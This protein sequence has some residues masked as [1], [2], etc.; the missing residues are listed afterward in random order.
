MVPF[1]LTKNLSL[2]SAPDGFRFSPARSPQSLNRSHPCYAASESAQRCTRH[3]SSTPRSPPASA[4]SADRPFGLGGDSARRPVIEPGGR[5]TFKHESVPRAT[6]F[7]LVF[8]KRGAIHRTLATRLGSGPSLCPERSGL[9]GRG[10]R[11]SNVTLAP[12]MPPR[13]GGVVLTRVR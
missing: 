7:W 4:Q 6:A 9:N 8:E 1:G 13:Q 5:L 3:T 2:T 10:S 12:R 11:R